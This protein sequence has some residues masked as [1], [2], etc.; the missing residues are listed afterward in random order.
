MTPGYQGASLRFYWCLAISSKGHLFSTVSLVESFHPVQSESRVLVKLPEDF[1][2]TSVG[3]LY[4][5]LSDLV[6]INEQVEIDG[7]AVERVDAAALQIILA[8]Q[9]IPGLDVAWSGIS[10]VLE[11]AAELTGLSGP[12]GL[13]G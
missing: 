10:S 3:E 12:L 9:G 2:I 1:T 4:Q 6:G 5:S 11:E 7:S 13:V 8:L